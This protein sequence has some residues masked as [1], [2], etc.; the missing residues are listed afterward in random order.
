MLNSTKTKQKEVTFPPKKNS[1]FFPHSIYHFSLASMVIITLP[2]LLAIAYAVIAVTQYTKLSQHTL[3]NT[4]RATDGSR[5]V[6]ERLIS[7]ERNI[8]QFQ[9]LKDPE[10]FKVYQT[11][12]QKFVEVVESFKFEGV[13]FELQRKLD[14]LIKSEARLYDLII[15]N[16][17]AGETELK[18][19]DLMTYASLAQEAQQIVKQGRK[20]VGQEAE[21]LSLAADQVRQSLI[22]SAL[23]SVP[24]AFLLGLILV[25][26]LTRPIK[27]I[28]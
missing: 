25:Y 16:A 12:H 6:L 7:M 1:R 22:Y 15:Q 13:K 19:E 27:H 26:R 17:I 10:L 5:V 2:L 14:G 21:M 11:H 28:G 9:V 24:L 20:Q 3:I 18:K 4:V 23:F 8:R